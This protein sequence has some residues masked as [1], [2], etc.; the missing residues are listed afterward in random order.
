[1]PRFFHHALLLQARLDLNLTQ[2]QAAAAVG[3]DV[4]TYRRYES[5]AV[6]DA[7]GGFSVR[8]PTRRRMLERLA[9]ELGLSE[10]D[11]LVESPS[12]AAPPA[13]AT[14]EPAPR[15][16]SSL[17][18]KLS[19]HF[20][21][22]L[23]RARH[24]V[25]RGDVLAWLSAWATADQPPARGVV[26]VAL[27]GTG[28]TAVAER[29]VAGLGEEPRPGGVF[30]WSFYEDPRIEGFLARALRYFARGEE[31]APGER[32][33][34]LQEVL[35]EGPPHLLVLDGLERVQSD[36]GD[37]RSRGELQDP[38]LRRLFT[39]L[40]RGLGGARVLMTSR[41]PLVDLQAWEGNGLRTLSLAPL[42]ED[43]G[44]DL[45]RLWGL[46]GGGG[47]LREL[48]ASAGG[49]ALSVSMIGSYVGG[50]LGGDVRRF[51]EVPLA[52]AARDDALARRLQT[53]LSAYAR[54]LPERERDLLARLCVLGGG[55]GEESLEAIAQ[56]GGALAGSLS[57]MGQAELRRTLARLERLGLVFAARQ[58]QALYSTHP[59]LRDYFQSLLGV[60]PEHIHALERDRLAARLDMRP[61]P[62]PEEGAMLDAYEA[63]ML[64][65]LRSG[66]PVE[67]YELYER[68]LGGFPHLGL[69]LG[70]MS[71][72]A[73]LTATF[74]PEGD[75]R[76]LPESL[77][78]RVRYTLAYEGGLYAGALGQLDFA[79]RCY[80]TAAGLAERMEFVGGLVTGLR[81]LGYTERLRG[82]LT[83]AR[84]L[85]ERSL[86]VAREHEAW[87]HIA[88]T[89]A[90]LGLVLHD[91]GE[92]SA[93]DAHFDRARE[94]DSAPMARRALWQ[95]E[96][97][98]ALGRRELAREA[99]QRNLE[100][101]E[102]LGWHG[103]VA[104]CHTVLGLVA[105]ED[106]VASAG[107][108]LLL[109][110]AWARASNEVEMLLRCHELAARLALKEEQPEQ[111]LRE[112][113]QGLSL[114]TSCGFGL[115]RSRLACLAA[116]SVLAREP[117][118]G[119]DAA[120]AALEATVSEDAWGKAEALALAEKALEAAGQKARARELR[121][122]RC[123]SVER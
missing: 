29:L 100:A 25:G 12:A 15:E 9:A 41:F 8:H 93:A 111:A 89:T 102:H 67:A 112:A 115:F 119:V 76:R 66:H 75:P 27:G 28:K 86:S 24:F 73:R 96:H 77:P 68:S 84:L 79:V 10:E 30:V 35:G 22:A 113:E 82:R 80:E 3:V 99:T 62:P 4:R 105:V 34:R 31:A 70:D 69:R 45:L 71:R 72:G 114:A 49:H 55:V 61:H 51:E 109:A 23:Q 74:A 88:R 50:F 13:P 64:H 78:E 14:S 26:L 81:T 108:H 83:S 40:A 17:E 65:T 53:V 101:C 44:V 94:L 2:E 104:H 87:G 63:L 106:D 47:A 20:A 43:E 107:E 121:A 11:L 97:D 98:L 39:V 92:D 7:R 60:A 57:G 85:L 21:H 18:E 118:S 52:E 91:L 95:A 36:G 122:S 6:N 19:P 5:G 103:H 120:L 16:V 117:K 59:F 1:M 56:A 90:L 38:S 116:R 33:E 110:R 46:R 48:S 42:S 58:G 54:A 37:G 32:L 123:G